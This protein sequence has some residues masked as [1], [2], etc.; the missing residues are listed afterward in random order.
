MDLSHPPEGSI[1]G[2]IPKDLY[3][4][5]YITVDS[6]IEQIWQMGHGT[7]L[8]KIDIKSAFRLLLVHPADRH[9]LSMRWEQNIYIDTCLPFGLRY[10]PKIFNVLADLLSWYWNTTMF[11]L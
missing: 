6:A 5:Q 7:L 10:A 4:L 8:T 11:L 3:S 1:N 2:G 9:L